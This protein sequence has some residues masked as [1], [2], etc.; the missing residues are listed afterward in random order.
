[1]IFIVNETNEQL[2][3]KTTALENG[4]ATID[5][6]VGENMEG[7][8]ATTE[9]KAIA[10]A[11]SDRFSGEGEVIKNKISRHN[12]RLEN[13]LRMYVSNSGD[14]LKLVAVDSSEELPPRYTYV[15]DMIV[16]VHKADDIVTM[17]ENS[18]NGDV[19]VVDSEQGE[20]KI[21]IFAVKWYNWSKLSTPVSVN[22]NDEEVY[23]LQ[24]TTSKTI[25][26]RLINSVVR[27]GNKPNNKKKHR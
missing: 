18:L 15:K 7:T 3:L 5:L 26:G 10:D 13:P 12:L 27:K 19:R 6:Q 1:M 14:E 2:K 17:R 25:N 8:I 4:D 11:I 9:S 22:I 20:Y 16:V 23:Q 21:T 24:A